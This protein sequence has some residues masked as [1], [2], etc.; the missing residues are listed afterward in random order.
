MPAQRVDLPRL[1]LIHPPQLDLP[2]VRARDNQR[3]RVVE[4]RPIDAAVVSL[5][6]ILD[7]GVVA[8]KEI[9]HLSGSKGGNPIEAE[10]RR[11]AAGQRLARTLTLG[12]ALPSLLESDEPPGVASTEAA[13]VGAARSSGV[14]VFGSS[15]FRRPEMSQTRTV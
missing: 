13:I 2:V 5:E 9:L 12:M 4:G 1:G 8:A 15:F 7:G 14:S 3:Q 10:R 6:D 11:K